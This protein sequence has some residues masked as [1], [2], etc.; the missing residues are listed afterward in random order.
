MAEISAKLVKELRDKTGAGMMDCKKA[1]QE[2]NGDM[3]AAIAWLRQKGLAS[4]G[5]KAGRVTSE[6]LVDSY[7]HTGGR[8]GVLVEVN[9][10]TDFV[11]RNEKFKALVQDI[12]KQIAA[13]PNVEFVSVDD[14]PAEYKEKER[15]IALGSDALK[16]KPPEVKEKIV[17]GKLEK[18][19]KELCLLNQP[20]IRDQSKTVEE[21]VKEHIAELGENIQIRRFQ[22]FVLG[23]GIEKQET[24]LAEEVAAQTRAMSAAAKT[25]EAPAKV[26]ETATPEVSAPEPAAETTTDE[27]APEPVA[28]SEQTVE[29]V[30]E[31]AAESPEPVA[32][33]AAESKGFGAAA[34]KS[35][36]KSRTTKKKK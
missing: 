10:E 33:P 19:L 20:F 3:E 11:A 22:R 30:A 16:G 6:G 31:P 12:A 34:K 5:K 9:C 15:Q 4:A 2:S 8:I 23:E 26:A 29:P 7:I 25:A 36:G 14:I 35:G 28:V 17:A 18:T 27:P 24:N 21:L 13:C 1:L 32:E